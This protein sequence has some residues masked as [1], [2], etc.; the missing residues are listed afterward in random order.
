MCAV[1]DMR[2]NKT[3]DEAGDYA[4]NHNSGDE[5]TCQNICRYRRREAGA[6]EVLFR[7]REHAIE[8]GEK[9]L[10]ISYE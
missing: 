6:G 7:V 1:H 5:K 8:G 3:V 2:R 10:D 4:D 9:L